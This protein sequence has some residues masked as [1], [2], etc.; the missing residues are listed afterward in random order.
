[1]S[2][3]LAGSDD[4]LLSFGFIDSLAYFLSDYFDLLKEEFESEAIL[5][6]GSLFEE[7]NL[8]NLVLNLTHNNHNAK[9]S[10]QYGLEVF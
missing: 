8:A 7:K 4:K 10:N 5:L 1:M 9:F 3:K 6:T 2:F